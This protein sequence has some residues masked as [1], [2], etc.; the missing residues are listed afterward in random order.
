MNKNISFWVFSTE[1]LFYDE[2]R[3]VLLKKLIAILSMLSKIK[4][5]LYLKK[6]S[7]YIE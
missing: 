5:T 1:I 7:S 4:T 3:F 2:I 6:F